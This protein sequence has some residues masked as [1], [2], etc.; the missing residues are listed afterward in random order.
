MEIEDIFERLMH[1]K[2]HF[3]I[4]DRNIVNPRIDGFC[5]LFVNNI[6][7]FTFYNRFDGPFSSGR[8]VLVTV[9]VAKT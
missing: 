9:V 7:V 3:S 6:V 1:L 5:F 8:R 4:D 2:F